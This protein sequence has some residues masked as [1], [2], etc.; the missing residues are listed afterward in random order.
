M[1]AT[2]PEFA[3][4]VREMAV[5]KGVRVDVWVIEGVNSGL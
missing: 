2:S 4:R 1:I 3:D 5:E